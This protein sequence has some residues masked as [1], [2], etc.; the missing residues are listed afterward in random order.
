MIHFSALDEHD[1]FERNRGIM[2]NYKRVWDGI[3]VPFL[4]TS[5]S[6]KIRVGYDELRI[7]RIG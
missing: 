5:S 1:V 2:R 3:S 6:K 4:E 7:G